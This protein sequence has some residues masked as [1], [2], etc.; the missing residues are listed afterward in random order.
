MV[1]A[2]RHRD[3]GLKR[4]AAQP[5]NVMAEEFTSQQI[6]AYIDAI[7]R[8][9]ALGKAERR[10]RLLE[11]LIKAE[12]SGEGRS[13]KAYSIGLDVFDRAESF[14]PSSDS[15]VRV[16]VGRLRNGLAL[17]EASE[18][19]T[20][21]IIVEIPVGTYQPILRRRDPSQVAVEAP[22]E[23]APE[24]T[25]ALPSSLMLLAAL[26]ILLSAAVFFWRSDDTNAVANPTPSA[27]TVLVRS[28]EG[29]ETMA[30]RAQGVITRALVRSRVFNVVDGGAMSLNNDQPR[31]AYALT[32]YADRNPT[33]GHRLEVFLMDVQ[34]NQIV[35]SK[36]ELIYADDHIDDAVESLFASELRVRLFSAS[37]RS[38]EAQDVEDLTP[39]ELFVLATWVPGVAENA[40]EWEQERIDLMQLVLQKD[41]GFG[42]AHSVIADKL[43]Y[44][45]NVYE[46]AN[47]AASADASHRHIQ[48]ARELSPLDADAMFNVAQALWHGGEIAESTKMM[49]RVL[50]LNQGHQLAQ[51][52]EKVIP[53][54]CAVPPEDTVEQAIA[55]DAA[56]AKDNPIRWL[57]LTWIG[58][59]YANQKDFATALEY[60]EQAALIFQVPYSFMRKAMVLNE[61]GRLD[62]AITV[63]ESQRGNWP[64]ISAR[65]FA[66]TTY[67][68][69]C[70]ESSAPQAIVGMYE[71][72]ADALEARGQ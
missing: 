54:T 53:F 39:A 15:I 56:L 17:F 69:L 5:E 67:P 10:L 37:K 19:A 11:H 24:P 62:D 23:A 47:T 18:Y 70:A 41:E 50:E 21:D 55:F 26:A 66:S 61:L 12:V 34:T 13:L 48:R 8:S 60:E 30:K 68:R 42:G 46:P 38:L 58:W 63:I 44:L 52:L 49:H 32:G 28:F 59:L 51:F 29:D 57:T 9:G 27:I 1:L 72:L 22:Q 14:D 2:G 35:W 25:N 4:D 71:R 45:A 6:T 64:D 36:S 7:R 16:E 65:F 3:V 20:T 31:S 43:R 40:V 33:D